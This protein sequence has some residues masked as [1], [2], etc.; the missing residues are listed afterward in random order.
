VA[1]FAIVG[2]G[3]PMGLALATHLAGTEESM[4]LPVVPM[5]S[6]SE[7]RVAEAG[8][9]RLLRDL[10][11]GKNI[12]TQTPRIFPSLTIAGPRAGLEPF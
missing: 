6:G 7:A 11:L 2:A 8:G 3:G 12:S 4:F 1:Q 10:L 5:Q 9:D